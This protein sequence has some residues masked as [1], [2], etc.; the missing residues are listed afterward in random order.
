M[1][2]ITNIENLTTIDITEHYKRRWDVEVFFKFIKQLLNFKHLIS[3]NENVIKAVL[4]VTIIAL[5]CLTS[6]KKLN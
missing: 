6:Y 3:R 2:F 1:S 5:I 4:Y